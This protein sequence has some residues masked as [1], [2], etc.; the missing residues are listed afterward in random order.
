VSTIKDADDS[1][2]YN[3]LVKEQLI[4]MDH[5]ATTP[6]ATGVVE[7]MHP[8]FSETF[9]NAASRFHTQG[10]RARDAVEF[11]RQEIASFIG[12]NPREIIF[13]SG[14]TE[15]LNIALQGLARASAKPGHFVST[16]IEHPA[17]LDT[18]RALEVQGHRTTLVPVTRDGLVSAKAVSAA[19]ES[20][21]I[22]VCVIGASNEIGTI[23]P[24]AEIS[25]ACRRANVPLISD[26]TQW[27]GNV[28]FDVQHL[29]V[30]FAT[31]SA[32]KMYGPKGIGCL[33][34]RNTRP[35]IAL[36]GLIHGG[37]HERG[38]RSG[39][40]NVPAIVGFR[41]AVR[42]A[43]LEMEEAQKHTAE[44]RD[45][46]FALL[47]E[48]IAG[49]HL[50]GTMTDRLPNNLNISIEGVEGRRLMEHLPT[51]AL[52][53]GSACSSAETEPSHVIRALGFGTARAVTALRFGLGR[54]TTLSE[55]NEVARRV[56]QACDQIRG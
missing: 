2:A 33:Y 48:Q 29:G 32:H 43:S 1:I 38:L 53:T 35:A 14:A 28:E 56:S 23:Q 15:S 13:T 26:T 34:V 36:S 49:V 31:I 54:K 46:L 19:I 44:L 40:L 3:E 21:T 7:A 22:A 50:N 11:A 9:G 24:L 37:G 18:L 55:V 25:E 12:A 5:H 47:S 30:D 16:E 17:V 20:D 27:V 39:T 45:H 42:I 52:S 10:K 8:Y 4:Y 41:E 51:I 6:C